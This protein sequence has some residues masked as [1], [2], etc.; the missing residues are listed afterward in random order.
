MT[1]IVKWPADKVCLIIY[2]GKKIPL[3][4]ENK[5]CRNIKNLRQ[6]DRQPTEKELEEAALQFVRKVSGYRKPS[7]A[8]EEAFNTAVAD[9]ASVTKTLFQKL[10]IR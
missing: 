8:N 6:T 3:H 10:I 9:I 7:A 4:G 1:V 2:H 5:M